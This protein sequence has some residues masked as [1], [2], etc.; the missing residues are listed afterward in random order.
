MKTGE[1]VLKNFRT[2]QL[3]K[4][5]YHGCEQL[6]LPHNLKDQ[7]QRASLSVVLNIAEGSAKPSP[8][9]RRRFYRIALGSLRETQALLDLTGAREL[10][11]LADPVGGCLYRL[12]KGV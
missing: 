10:L 9:D 6:K 2:Y 8:K 12:C 1:T 4:Q 5:L 7:L 11:E 3:A